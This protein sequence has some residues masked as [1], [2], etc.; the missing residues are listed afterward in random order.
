MMFSSGRVSLL[1]HLREV[2]TGAF[3]AFAAAYG[4][5]SP[6]LP[7]D[8]RCPDASMLELGRSTASTDGTRP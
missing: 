1:Q 8:S 2:L 3:A 5:R 7:A 6:R 4:E